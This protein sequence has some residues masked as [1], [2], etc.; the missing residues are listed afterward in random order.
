VYGDTESQLSGRPGVCISTLGPGTA[1][2]FAGLAQATLEGSPV[3]GI[4]ADVTDDER[5]GLWHQVI[6]PQRSRR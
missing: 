2:L 4:T 3:F 1:N 6:D 5:A